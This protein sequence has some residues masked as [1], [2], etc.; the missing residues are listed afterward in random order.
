MQSDLLRQV[1]GH[2]RPRAKE[3]TAAGALLGGLLWAYW[4]ALADMARRW[5]DDSRYSHGYLVPLFALFLL[6]SRRGRFAAGLGR[7]SWWGLPCLAGGLALHFAGTYLYLDWLSGVALLP[8]LA[9]ACLLLGGRPALRWAWPAVAFLV[10]MVP[11]PFRVETALAHPLQ[12]VATLVSTY[13]L[14]TLG[15][16]AFAEGNV[17]RMG[18]VRL[19]VVEACSGLSMLMIFFA[20]STAVA[21]FV[22]RLLDKALIVAS[23]VPIALAANIT[24]IAVTGALHK[25]V[26]SRLADLVFHDLAGWLMMVL[27][28]ALLWLEFRLLSWV[29]IPAPVREIVPLRLPGAAGP[30]PKAG[31]KPAGRRGPV[32]LVPPASR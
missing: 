18:A 2:L 28:L 12:R 1:C 13:A 20:V 30:R 22:P 19:G 25:T 32:P 15:F 16:A 23:A 8:C 10:F 27:A 6:W 17:I 9:G 14:Q 21:A 29:L 24:R 26:G 4:P 11:L 31:R 5:G 7:P 3:A